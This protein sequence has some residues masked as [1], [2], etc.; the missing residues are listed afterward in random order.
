MARTVLTEDERVVIAAITTICV[1]WLFADERKT[2]LGLIAHHLPHVRRAH[3]LGNLVSAAEQL[4]HAKT[5]QEW[6]VA[7]SAA[8]RALVPVLRIDLAG[9]GG[10]RSEAR[11]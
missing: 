7:K 8:A 3:P 11:S 5:V 4:Q 2:L 10:A 6:A 1:Q 9:A